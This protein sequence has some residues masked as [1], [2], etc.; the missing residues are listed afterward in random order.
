[1]DLR[2]HKRAYEHAYTL[3]HDVKYFYL[4]RQAFFS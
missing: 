3:A 1:M 2:S 4:N